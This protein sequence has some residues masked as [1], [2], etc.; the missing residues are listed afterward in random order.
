MISG[1]FV[2]L[3]RLEAL[4]SYGR[5]DLGDRTNQLPLTIKH[6]PTLKMNIPSGREYVLG[7]RFYIRVRGQRHKSRREA[8]GSCYKDAQGRETM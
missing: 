6:P 2:D 8:G 5:P 4:G 1:I 3:G 7:T